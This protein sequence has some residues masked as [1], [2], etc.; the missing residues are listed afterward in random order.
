MAT[1]YCLKPTPFVFPE[2]GHLQAV[3]TVL[4]WLY[5]GDFFPL[6]NSK[7]LDPSFRRL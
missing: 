7:K 5:D 3:S 1:A 6:N 2:E 4:L